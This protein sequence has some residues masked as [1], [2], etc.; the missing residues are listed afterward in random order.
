M[1]ARQDFRRAGVSLGVDRM[2]SSWLT[3]C[4]VGSFLHAT[5]ES[6]LVAKTCRERDDY[7]AA[8]ASASAAA[9]DAAAASV[10]A[11]LLLVLPLLL[12]LLL[13]LLASIAGE[14]KYN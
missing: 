8:V 1:S 4:A 9:A 14:R 11:L 10:A 5:V 13:L 6:S 12:L 3:T 2:A 7:A